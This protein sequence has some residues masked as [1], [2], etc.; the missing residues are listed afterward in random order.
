[1]GEGGHGLCLVGGPL[2]LAEKMLLQV[3]MQLL[4]EMQD[5]EALAA[6]VAL[7][8]MEEAV[9]LILNLLNQEQMEVSV[10]RE[11]MEEE[12]E[13]AA[14]EGIVLGAFQEQ[15]VQEVLAVLEEG[16]EAA[17]V[18]GLLEVL[19]EEQ[20]MV[21]MAELVVMVEVEGVVVIAGAAFSALAALAALD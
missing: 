3:Q 8:V 18:L 20:G 1:M 2:E 5:M 12:A 10:E 19:L 13:E 15:E 21:V 4:E 6:E 11:V 7:V 17:E 16:A 14:M 9:G